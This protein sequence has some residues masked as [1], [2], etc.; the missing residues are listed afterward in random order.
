MDETEKYV[1]GLTEAESEDMA[2]IVNK[3]I[4]EICYFPIRTISTATICLSITRNLWV[5]LLKLQQY[6]A[7]KR[8]I[9]R[10]M[11]IE[12]EA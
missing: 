1:D 3:T 5:H 2:V 12:F 11:L 4:N 9:H 6:R 10:L 8:K 7:L